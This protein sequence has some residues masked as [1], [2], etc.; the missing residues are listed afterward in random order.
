MLISSV[1]KSI[2]ASNSLLL[3]FISAEL[4][5]VISCSSGSSSKLIENTSTRYNAHNKST[6]HRVVSVSIL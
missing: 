3:T 6:N 5:A 4:Y 1:H 2:T